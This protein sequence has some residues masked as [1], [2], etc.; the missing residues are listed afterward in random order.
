MYQQQQK[1]FTQNFCGIKVI[2]ANLQKSGQTLFCSPKKLTALIP[3]KQ[4][5][6]FQKIT[7]IK[8]LRKYRNAFQ[9]H[10]PSERGTISTSSPS[11]Q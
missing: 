2:Q 1:S 10:A 4:I 6:N 9:N 5:T 3:L 11:F 7:T 8:F